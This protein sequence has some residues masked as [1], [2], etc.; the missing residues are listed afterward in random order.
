VQQFEKA[1]PQGTHSVVAQLGLVSV[2]GVL[3]MTMIAVARN[4]TLTFSPKL[5]FTA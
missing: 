4:P 1:D 2:M 3:I 5:V